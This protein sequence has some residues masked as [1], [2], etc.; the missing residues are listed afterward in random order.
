MIHDSQ[1]DAL[2]Q[3]ICNEAGN[4]FRLRC[5]TCQ[6][7]DRLKALLLVEVLL[8]PHGEELSGRP[9]WHSVHCGVCGNEGDVVSFAEPEV[10]S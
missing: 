6:R 4:A 5:P 9:S 8:L 2:R 1:L 3:H 10:M 7:D